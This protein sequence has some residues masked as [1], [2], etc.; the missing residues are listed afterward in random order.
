MFYLC[1]YIQV[2]NAVAVPVARALGYS[3]GQA[4]QQGEFSGD[5]TP[6]FE[7]PG[8]FIPGREG[9]VEEK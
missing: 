5:Q 7:L 6:L 9:V 8:N 3:L 2:G 4:Y 1:R